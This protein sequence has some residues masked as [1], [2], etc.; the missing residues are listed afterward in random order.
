MLKLLKYIELP[1]VATYK[2]RWVRRIMI[3]V[4]T[5]QELVRAVYYVF[6]GA[7]LWWKQP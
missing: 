3:V 1:H 6:C 4:T 7:A 5:P 2:S